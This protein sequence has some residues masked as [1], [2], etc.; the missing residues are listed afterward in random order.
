MDPVSRRHFLRA[1]GGLIAA[2]AISQALPWT[3]FASASVAA[4][5][6]A[7]HVDG[8]KSADKVFPQSV[9]SG[10][11]TPSGAVLW[12]RIAP[13]HLDRKGAIGIEVA[14]DGD[15]Q[16]VVHRS[17]LP[18]TSAAA[19][20]AHTIRFDLD[21]LL[22]ADRHYF[23]RF[24]HNGTSTRTGR[25]RTLPAEDADIDQVR[26]AVLTCMNFQNGYF[27]A[28]GHIADDEVDYIIHLGDFIYEYNGEASYNGKKF[29][30]RGIA[31]PSG[32]PRMEDRE[33]LDYVWGRY[34]RDA[35]LQAALERHTIICT[36]DDHEITNDRSFDHDAGHH[37]GDGSFH[38]TDGAAL[39]RFFRDGAQAYF[40]W[41]PLRVPID[42]EAADPLDV[43][44]LYRDFR[45]GRLVHLWMLD[46]RWFRTPPAG[47]ALEPSQESSDL[48][49]SE[50][51]STD[52]TLLGARQKDWLAAGLAASDARWQLFGQ[53][54]Q[55]SPLAATMPGTSVYLNLD[56]WDG[57]EADRQWFQERLAS[58]RNVVVLT[59][60]LHTFMVGYIKKDYNA[61][62]VEP[63]GN[64]VA[65]EFMTPGVTSAGLGEII[66]EQTGK[67]LTPG[68]DEVMENFV[69][70]GNPH[71]V[72]F[73][74]TRHG[75]SIVEITKRHARYYGYV[76]DKSHNGVAGNRMLLSAWECPVGR[77]TLRELQHN[78]PS[79]LSALETTAIIRHNDPRRTGLPG[80]DGMGA[81]FRVT[82]VS[83]LREVLK[84]PGAVAEGVG[85]GVVDATTAAATTI[86]RLSA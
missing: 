46:E 44:T 71:M 85:M 6:P 75:Y 70:S 10:D 59:G 82:S 69:L 1:A 27:G 3:R 30:G 29:P 36:W 74:S 21:G 49:D 9:A 73:N 20:N 56:A 54:V 52:A 28:L 72:H 26:F 23:Y 41:L 68:D 15:M 60:D 57:Y 45:F 62:V 34:R 39:D 65:V 79:G 8:R 38:V 7:F 83:R 77:V 32:A 61:Q 14:T 53:Q 66:E 58:T 24:I 19:E 2:G 67:P 33:D 63:Q 78:S 4:D 64:R 80:F 86:E 12:T 31:L 42:A 35:H 47:A 5:D 84:R 50:R 55:V 40:D 37:I 81:R 25:L 11:P 22:D 13:E 76:V 18:V 51:V 17:V 43:I 16:D 48:T